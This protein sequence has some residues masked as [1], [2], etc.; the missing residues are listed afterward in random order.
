MDSFPKNP[1]RQMHARQPLMLSTVQLQKDIKNCANTCKDSAQQTSVS[2][3]YHRCTNFV[4][5]SY[6][7]ANGS[8]QRCIFVPGCFANC[9]D[10][11]K[12]VLTLDG[13]HLKG[14]YN[15]SGV[16]LT[17]SM[18]DGS[19]KNLLVALAIVPTENEE[20]WTWFL[21]HL[22]HSNLGIP[23][24]FFFVSDRSKTW[25]QYARQKQP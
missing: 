6:V 22:K 3:N 25:R 18:K 17:A 2:P 20:E 10:L 21:Q 19:N 16:F 15:K 8:F 14:I 12:K 9:A 1:S 13:C 24:R 23:A 11:C 7:R 4:I 5:D